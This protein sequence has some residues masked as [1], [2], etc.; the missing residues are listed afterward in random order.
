MKTVLA[1]RAA[2]AL[3]LGTA[4]AAGGLPVPAGSAAHAQ[5][6]T[7][8]FRNAEIQAFIDDVSIVTGYTFIVDPEVRGQVTITSQTPLTEAEVF[9]VF[10]ATLR[11]HGYAAVRTGPGV[12]QIL[13]ET[14]GARAGAPT[15]GER[16]GDVFLTS[17]VRL[18]NVSA[19][20][21]IRSVGPL[22]SQS[23]A[24]NASDAGNLVVI[25]DYASNVQAIEDVLRSMAVSY[26]HLRA[27]ET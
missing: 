12:Y 14:E 17:V 8:N 25:V 9:Q 3:L 16:D 21:A 7:L 11:T 10:L 18:N 24:V 22:V 20:E 15:R 13:P 4:I 2:A 5:E 19:R 6:H 23:G 26:T 1:A 27:H